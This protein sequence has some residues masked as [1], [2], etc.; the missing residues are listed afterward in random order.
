MVFEG[1]CL[2]GAVRYRIDAEPVSAG[3]CCCR[4][5]REAAGAPVVAWVAFPREAVEFT[6]GEPHALQAS[7]RAVR[8][9]CPDCGGVLTFEYSD[10]RTID[11]IIASLD[12]PGSTRP[13]YEMWASS[14]PPWPAQEHGGPQYADNPPEAP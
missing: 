12:D 9:F 6:R 2:C 11:V 1:G 3:Y 8:R 10:T 14:K 5:C 7:T 4:M 13:L